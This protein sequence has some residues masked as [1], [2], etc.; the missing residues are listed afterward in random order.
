[1]S[2]AASKW[3]NQSVSEAGLPSRV[4]R[5]FVETAALELGSEQFAVILALSKLPADWSK[6]ET[7]RKLEP[8][9]SAKTYATIQA[10]MRMHF[11]RGARGVLLRVGQRLWHQLM[12][13][14]ALAS[15]AQAAVVRRLPLNARRKSTLEMLAG[16]LGAGS[17]DITVHTLDLDLLLVD[18]A[19][20][21]TDSYRDSS[22]ICFVTQGL[23]QESLLWATGQGHDVEET[24]CKA[25]GDNACEFKVITGK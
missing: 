14:A 12:D 15:K 17:G 8:I 11:G 13:D 16:F 2:I 20:P 18:H 25:R 4:L 23:V 24:S 5:R 3:E 19:S 9:Q 7:F 6:P 22:P 21:T 10:G 1:M